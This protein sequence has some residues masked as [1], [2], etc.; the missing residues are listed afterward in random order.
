MKLMFTRLVMVLAMVLQLQMW[1]I[2]FAETFRFILRRERLNAAI[3]RLCGLRLKLLVD[4]RYSV[5][6]II[7]Y[8]QSHL[9]QA[10]VIR[11]RSLSCQHDHIT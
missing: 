2:V 8:L 11:Y 9:R 5:V 6:R 7:L 10:D 3:V 1:S 4:S